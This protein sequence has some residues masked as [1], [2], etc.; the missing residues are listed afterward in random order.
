VFLPQT[1]GGSLMGPTLADQ[2]IEVLAVCIPDPV[3]RSRGPVQG[4]E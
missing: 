2:L 3:A 1:T 4:T